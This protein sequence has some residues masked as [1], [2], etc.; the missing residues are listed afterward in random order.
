MALTPEIEVEIVTK[1]RQTRSPFK[2]A[3]A[4]GVSVSEVFQVIDSNPDSSPGALEERYGGLG[5][6]NMQKY[7]VA[8]RRAADRQWDNTDTA[9]AQAREN[10]EKG[11]HLLAT[12]RD[13]QWLILYSIPRVG[14]ADPQQ[15]YFLPEVA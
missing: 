3:D 12:G 13:G 14:R 7:T 15:D 9:I 1:Y 10:Y 2:T 6:P 11:T 4:V 8:R 5:R